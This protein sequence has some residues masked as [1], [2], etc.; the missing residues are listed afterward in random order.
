MSTPF[1]CN[2][3]DHFSRR[4]FLTGAT[5]GALGMLG[6]NGMVQ[7]KNAQSLASQQKRVVVFWL[8]GG[9]SQLETWD[10]K[11]N[12]DTGGPF[13]A[14]PTSVPGVHISELLPQTAQQMHHLALVRGVNTKENNHGK[15]AYIMQTGHRQTP[16]FDFPYLGSAFSSLLTAKDNALP[17]YISI[18]SGGSAKEAS[19]LGP[20]NVPITLTGTNAPKNLN[21]PTG[22]TQQADTRRRNLRERF[23]KRFALGRRG[24][25]SEVY[26]SS[27]DSA[28]SLMAQKALFDFSKFDPKDLARYGTHDFSKHCLMARK[29]VEAGVT[30]TRVR[31]TN[32]DS[33]SENFNFHVEQLGEF[34]RPFAAFVS[35]LAD[36]GLL[37]H[38]LIIVMCEFGR[39]PRINQRLGRDHWGTAWSI[40]LGGTGVQGGAVVGKT[41]AN[42]T[43][44]I[45]REVNG[46]H[47][48]HTYY[49]AVGLD[50]TDPFYDK[51]RPYEKADPKTS[52][53]KEILA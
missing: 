16:G 31:H 4:G 8:S 48:F 44:V 43:K 38:T 24:A 40:A 7:A 51:G 29:L 42:G 26:S 13:Q 53:L 14:I 2:S 35:D 11:P 30:F 36:R 3:A 20:R 15:G 37:E 23:S 17:G 39:T 19:F 5:G 18:G 21:L 45:E 25:D 41:N 28:A 50:P 46:G 9:V 6:F 49:R 34:D 10:P 47:L 1:A 32:Y 12:T 22:L 52:E 33:H 27:Y